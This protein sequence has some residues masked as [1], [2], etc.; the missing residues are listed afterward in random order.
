MND[1][2]GDHLMRASGSQMESLMYVHDEE[3]NTTGCSL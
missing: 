2:L 1:E 3:W